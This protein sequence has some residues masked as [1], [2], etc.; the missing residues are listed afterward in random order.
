MTMI[1]LIA[2]KAMRY[3]GKALV[4]GDSFQASSRNAKLLKAIRKADDAPPPPP[5]PPAPTEAEIRLTA[6]RDKYR[7]AKG[8]DADGRWGIDRLEG[9]LAPKPVAPTYQRRDM[10]A[11]D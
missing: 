1:D 6:L 3:G 5:P 2:T 10:R 9:E 8:E 11:K 4:P 7:A